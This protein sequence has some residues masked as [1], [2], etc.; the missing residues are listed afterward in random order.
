M[1]D[2]F[3]MVPVLIRP[4]SEIYRSGGPSLDAEELER[5]D[6]CGGLIQYTQN[7]YGLVMFGKNEEPMVIPV[8]QDSFCARCGHHIKGWSN[9]DENK[10]IIMIFEDASESKDAEFL[11]TMKGNAISYRKWS[12]EKYKELMDKI[13]EFKEKRWKN[14]KRRKGKNK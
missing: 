9:A 14:G 5:C 11:L 12:E 3:N 8:E 10:D 13:K 1:V 7:T 4:I 6:N 2:A